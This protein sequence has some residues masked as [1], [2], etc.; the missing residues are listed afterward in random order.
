MGGP[1][2]CTGGVGGTTGGIT[3]GGCS[4]VGLLSVIVIYVSSHVTVMYFLFFYA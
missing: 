2:G 4:A 1:G 3:G